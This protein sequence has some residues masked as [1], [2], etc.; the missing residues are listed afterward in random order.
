MSSDKSAS[1]VPRDARARRRSADRNVLP[2]SL[3]DFEDLDLPRI[4]SSRNDKIPI[5]A[6]PPLG[7][8]PRRPAALPAVAQGSVRPTPRRLDVRRSEREHFRSRPTDGAEPVALRR[9]SAPTATF[10]PWARLCAR[11][12]VVG[13]ITVLVFLLLAAGRSWLL[14][15]LP[16]KHDDA[17]ISKRSASAAVPAPGVTTPS[18]QPPDAGRFASPA[19]PPSSALPGQKP[20]IAIVIP[21]N[22]Q[23]DEKP[24]DFSARHEIP[25]APISPAEPVEAIT[26]SQQLDLAQAEDA[27]RVQERLIELG[28]LVGIADGAWGPRSRRALQDFRIARKAG[29][30]D[31]WDE[32]TQTLLFAESGTD[33][34]PTGEINYIGGWGADA[35]QCRQSPLIVTVRRAEAFGAVC[36]FNST[37]RESADVWRLQ[38]TCSNNRERW[39]AKIRLTL[40]GNQLTWSSER[41]T[42]TYTRCAN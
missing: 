40:A 32:A 33:A 3:T 38:A 27:K 22:P 31:A 20:T 13:G 11:M 37:S 10:E 19:H 39:K 35:A 21:R 23:A 34:L 15:A 24:S 4:A 28:F 5:L 9:A 42:A 17:A 36:E 18:P 7:N 16:T 2:A 30:S 12:G 41:G 8:A 29:N 6:S 26:G 14:P 25:P 1:G